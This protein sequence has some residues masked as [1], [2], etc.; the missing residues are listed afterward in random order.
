MT[1]FIILLVIIIILLITLIYLVVNKFNNI[2]DYRLDNINDLGNFKYEVNNNISDKLKN[3]ELS[4]N[5]KISGSITDIA[6]RLSK[7]D[8]AQR[9]IDKLSVNILGLQSILNDKKVRGVFGEVQ[10]AQVL[11]NIFGDKKKYY[12]LQYKMAN[13]RIVDAVIFAPEPLGLIPIDSKFPLENYNKIVET[14]AEVEEYK[15]KFA[16]DVKKHISDISAKY[17]KEQL[18]S[19]AILFIPAEA[20][21]SYITVNYNDIIEYAYEN[22]VW[23]ASPMTLM[24]ILTSIQMVMINIQRNEFSI[25]LHEELL[26]LSNEFDRYNLRWEKVLKDFEKIAS[27][28]KDV[29][30]TS[31]KIS[32]KFDDIKNVNIEE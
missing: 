23:I 15:K 13:D 4:V 9:N 17:I 25:K 26:K 21:F 7:I 12:D 30:T 14:N 22:K 5:S 18:T 24:A 2:K 16:S 28:I 3:L 32:K 31:N 27:D 19:Q 29:S 1:Y 10:L 8:E 6:V 20:I 11:Y